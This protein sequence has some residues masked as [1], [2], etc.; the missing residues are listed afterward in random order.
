MRLKDINFINNYNEQVDADVYVIDCKSQ[1]TDVILNEEDYS[2]GHIKEFYKRTINEKDLFVIGI[3]DEKRH[4]KYRKIGGD[5]GRLLNQK[6]YQSVNVS[7]DY[8]TDINEAK[9][10]A[11]IEGWL[12]GTHKLDTYKSQKIN[13]FVRSCFIQTKITINFAEIVEKA[14]CQAES[15]LLARTICQEP[16]NHFNSEDFVKITKET[17]KNSQVKVKIYQDIDLIEKQMIG[18]LTVSKGSNYKPALIELS[19]QTDPTKPL[20]ALVGKGLTFDMGGNNIKKGNDLS[21]A[22][23]DMGGA[24]AVIGALLNISKLDLKANVVGLLCVTENMINSDAMLPGDVIHYPNG[25]TVQICNTDAEGRLVLADGIIHADNLGA[26]LIV[27]IAT[28]T[29]SVGASLGT[30]LAGLW[31]D[32]DLVEIMKRVANES[33]ELVWHMPLVDDYEKTLDSDYADFKNISTL[34]MAGSIT[35]ALFLRKFINGKKWAHLDIAAMMESNKES[36]E[37]VKGAT[38]YGV[39]LLTEFIKTI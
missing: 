31:G 8:C 25:K 26:Q 13:N 15:V 9:I 37:F 19:Y 33:G 10:Q 7:F 5:I 23:F 16:F 11:F 6:K 24:S 1:F 18:L 35:A 4:Y 30:S 2:F 14:F 12:L 39:R 27:D 3:G 17:F 34:N 21:N 38:G 28:L 32:N 36:G 29:G 22:R 20:T